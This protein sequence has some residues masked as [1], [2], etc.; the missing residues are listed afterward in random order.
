MGGILIS[1][2][3]LSHSVW[4]QDP[5]AAKPM[6]DIPSEYQQL[7]VVRTFQD[8]WDHGA[9]RVVCI[10][11]YRK[12]DWDLPNKDAFRGQ[13]ILYLGRWHVFIGNSTNGECLR[14]KIELARFHNRNVMVVGTVFLGNPATA[15]Y[16]SINASIIQDI[17]YIGKGRKK[18]GQIAVSPQ[19]PNDN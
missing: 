8:I 1:L 14:P 15:G 16:S 17:Q 7:P 6:H 13:A 3:T 5:A 19:Q 4:A 11:T 18:G 9:G 10:G 12:F 2:L